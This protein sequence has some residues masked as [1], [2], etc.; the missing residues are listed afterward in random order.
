MLMAG[1]MNTNGYSIV[2]IVWDPHLDLDE[3]KGLQSLIENY[4]DVYR[5]S[6]NDG[7]ESLNTS[8]GFFSSRLE[9]MDEIKGLMNDTNQSA[10]SNQ[11]F[12]SYINVAGLGTDDINN[13]LIETLFSTKNLNSSLSVG[14]KGNPNMG[15]VV[16]GDMLEGADWF[17]SLKTA[18]DGDDRIFII[19]SIFGGTGASGYPLLEKK[20]RTAEDEPKLKNALMGAVTVLPYYGLTDPGITSSDIDSANFYTKAKSALAYYE[21]TIQSDYLYYVG[22]KTI[23]QFYENDEK[24]QE[25]TANF[26]ELIAATAL[27]DFLK[28]EKPERRQYV[29]RAIESDEESMDIKSLGKGYNDLVKSV[30]DFMLLRHLVQILPNEKWFPLKKTRGFNGDFYH[31]AAFQSLNDFTN[32]YFQWYSELAQNKRAFAP[33]SMNTDQMS[34]W[35]KNKVLDAKNESYYLLD[36]I[37][38]S[39]DRGEKNAINMFRLFLDF[40]YQSIDSYTRKIKD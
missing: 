30:A 18:I 13:F 37:K 24:K 3:R 33:L 36:M 26:I 11:K 8:D 1:G 17:K 32:G 38:A 2:P 14:F 12:R 34:G 21:K 27:F 23:K 35:I 40:A 28:R 25:D 31:D 5:R 22:E 19:S 15:T 7:T 39:N 6:V 29:Q 16:L 4:K 20:I 10:G 9:T